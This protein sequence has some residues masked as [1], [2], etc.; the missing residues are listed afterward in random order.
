MNAHLATLLKYL[1]S[2]LSPS[3][4]ALIP[5][6]RPLVGN[7]VMDSFCQTIMGVQM[8]AQANWV[9]K[10]E[11]ASSAD[12]MPVK[13][14]SVYKTASRTFL[15]LVLYR[16]L[17]PWLYPS[18]IFGLTSAG[19]KSKEAVGVLHG[20]TNS[21]IQQRKGE[22][23]E[24]LL[25]GDSL[26][27]SM[28]KVS[29]RK[30]LAFL[31]LL[32]VHHLKGLKGTHLSLRDV[33]EEVD[34]FMAAGTDTTSTTLQFAILLIGL[35]PDKQVQGPPSNAYTGSRDKERIRIFTLLYCYLVF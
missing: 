34:I 19:R 22:V 33:R 35:N 16:G 11:A 4:V 6:V 23:E 26:E 14:D 15:R 28:K 3:G 27:A 30:R 10:V 29:A 13:A 9:A 20:F 5:D 1:N 32:L 21:V 7:L 8:N 25:K 31:D 2:R 24:T 12:C 18:C 17:R